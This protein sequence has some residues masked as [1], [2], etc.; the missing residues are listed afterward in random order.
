MI[1][2]PSKEVNRLSYEMLK[3]HQWL[4]MHNLIF[5]PEIAMQIKLSS[6]YIMYIMSY[7]PIETLW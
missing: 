3:Y 7:C 1:P 4:V 5:Y 2:C 6:N